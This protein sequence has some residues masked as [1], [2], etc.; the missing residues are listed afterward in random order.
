LIHSRGPV[1]PLADSLS[2]VA[3]S[4]CSSATSGGVEKAS[5]IARGRAGS[6][7]PCPALERPLW[8]VYGSC[9]PGSMPRPGSESR[10]SCPSDAAAGSGAP[11]GGML[12]GSCSG[13]ADCG[14]PAMTMVMGPR[15]CAHWMLLLFCTLLLTFPS[16]GTDTVSLIQFSVC[17]PDQL[18]K[19]TCFV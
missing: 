8:S 18:W 17:C 5:K 19:P 10:R 4:S 16:H 11:L 1:P 9:S 2:A 3:D 13:P 7:R 15:R 6:S 12:L 14:R